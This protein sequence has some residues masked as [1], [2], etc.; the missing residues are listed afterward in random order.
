MTT[1]IRMA[2][3]AALE[4]FR[5]GVHLVLP[6]LS[7]VM[8]ARQNIAAAPRAALPYATVE[9]T[10]MIDLA[11]P[12]RRVG[13][14]LP[15]LDED[16][17]ETNELEL[18]QVKD[19]VVVLS[20]FGDDGP[21]LLDVLPMAHGR[22]ASQ[23]HL[24]AAG[25]AVRTMADANDVRELRS[26]VHEAAAFQEFAITFCREDSSQVGTIETAEIMGYDA[27]PTE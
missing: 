8:I 10:R 24:E 13:D 27:I 14:V 20:V 1:I 7:E 21:D 15:D 3:S 19:M 16:E 4:A 23:A 12:Y 22:V 9:R 2:P 11:S 25:I 5:L 17:D 6:T 18:T 26:T